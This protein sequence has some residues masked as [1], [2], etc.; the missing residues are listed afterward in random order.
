VCVP[1]KVRPTE[2]WRSWCDNAE[3]RELIG[4]APRTELAQGLRATFAALGATPACTVN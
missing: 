2:I 1:C 3:A 4:W